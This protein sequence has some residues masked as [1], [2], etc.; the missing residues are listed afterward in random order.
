M[1]YGYAWKICPFLKREEKEWMREGKEQRLGKG[2]RGV[3]VWRGNYEE[4]DKVN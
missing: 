3:E 1:A 4:Y 2:L